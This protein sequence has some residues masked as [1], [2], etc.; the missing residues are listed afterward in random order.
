MVIPGLRQQGLI[1]PCVSGAAG[2]LLGG[3]IAAQ[4]FHVHGL[5]GFLS[6]IVIVL[7]PNRP[8]AARI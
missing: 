6:V 5:Q 1:L 3:W 8:P 7:G 4:A 2:T